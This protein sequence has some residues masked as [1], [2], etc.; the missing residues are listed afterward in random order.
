VANYGD[1][2]VSQYTIGTG[3]ALTAMTTAT[4]AAGSFPSSIVTIKPF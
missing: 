4:I 3:G 2:T 1:G